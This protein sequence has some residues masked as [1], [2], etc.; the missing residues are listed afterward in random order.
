MATTDIKLIR[1]CMT[2][3]DIAAFTDRRHSNILRDIREMSDSWFKVTGQGFELSEYT[4]STG[5]TLPMFKLTKAEILFVA[6]KYDDEI[7]AMIIIRFCQLEEEERK[8]NELM[9]LELSYYDNKSD[10]K[11]L[12]QR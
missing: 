3:L 5:R 4:D 6:S 2:S 10:I 11:D 1:D 9:Q 12:Y 8:R 7:R